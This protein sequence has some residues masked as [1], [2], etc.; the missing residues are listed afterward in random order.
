LDAKELHLVP[1][2][3]EGCL[4]KRSFDATLLKGLGKASTPR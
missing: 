1:Q 2:W 4:G 3:V